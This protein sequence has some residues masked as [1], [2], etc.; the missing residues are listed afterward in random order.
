MT[1]LGDLHFFLGMEVTRHSDHLN[2]S[3]TKYT[4]DFLQRVGM[5]D[6]K[7]I[8]SPVVSGSKLSAR[9]G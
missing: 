8:S 7:P 5:Q 9:E 3:Q 6:A 1:D 4:L 2:L